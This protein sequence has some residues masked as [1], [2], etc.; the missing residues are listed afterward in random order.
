[1]WLQGETWSINRR[2]PLARCW[3]KYREYYGTS[4]RSTRERGEE[5]V[6]IMRMNAGF[7]ALLPRKGFYKWSH[8]SRLVTFCGQVLCLS[9]PS[10][11]DYHENGLRW[12]EPFC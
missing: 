3:K 6:I 1:M 7:R 10:H 12:T 9:L 4:E 11:M 8:L 5:K 2:Q